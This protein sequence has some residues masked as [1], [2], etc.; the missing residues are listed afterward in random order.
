MKTYLRHRIENVVDVKE[1]IALE[2]LDFEG[3]YKDYEETH[4]FWELCYVQ[5]GKV[6]I[7]V[8]NQA[9]TLNDGQ[10]IIIAPDRKHSYRAEKGNENKAFVICF[11]SFTHALKSLDLMNFDL[12][13]NEVDCLNKIIFESKHT[14]FMN[15]KD[16]L[17]RISSPNF[18]G[19]QAIILQLEYLLIC[20]IRRLSKN[21][22]K[23]VFLSGEQFHADLVRIV[24][25]YFEENIGAKLS[26]KE[27]SSRVNYSRSFICKIFK[28][29]TGETLLN[30]FNR[31]K[32]E[33]AKRLLKN[34]DL[35]A[36]EI[37][38]SLGFTEPK[39]FGAVF[40]KFTGVSPMAYKKEHYGKTY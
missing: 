40:K 9:F 29:Q 14:F 33:E 22:E 39:Y 13:D 17:E 3:K 15:K 8:D 37:S 16:L 26:L 18:G 36:T 6:N 28:E 25:N 10:L 38:L 19:Q 31:L 5:K 30:R 32:T 35:S 11:E 23:I 7:T 4:G 34:T 24:L 20:L 1:L 12:D 27:I 21:Q 2:Y